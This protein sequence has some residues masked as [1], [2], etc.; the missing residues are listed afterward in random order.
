MFVHV[1]FAHGDTIGPRRPLALETLLAGH[2]KQRRPAKEWHGR[3]AREF[4]FGLKRIFP[5]TH[6]QD[7]CATTATRVR[8]R[9][10]ASVG[11]RRAIDGGDGNRGVVNDTVDDH[12]R[13]F[14]KNRR[15]VRRDGRELPRQLLRF[16]QRNFG[17]MHFDVMR[18]HKRFV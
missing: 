7:A 12:L 16:R 3:L 11:N 4:L 13:D 5:G 17:W 18:Y 8:Q 2:A 9:L 10:R 14:G 15:F 1:Q 6:R